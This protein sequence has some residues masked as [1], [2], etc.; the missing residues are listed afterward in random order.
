M[1]IENQT[2]IPLY[3]DNRNIDPGM[4]RYVS[5]HLFDNTTILSNKGCAE[6]TTEF[7]KR[8]ITCFGGIQVEESTQQD[9]QGHNIII[10][11]ESSNDISGD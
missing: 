8:S 11:K 4:V 10:V 1:L 6:I 3:V 2:S 9:M 7:Y 5:E